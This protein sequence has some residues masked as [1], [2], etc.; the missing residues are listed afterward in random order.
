MVIITG[1]KELWEP[2]P[3][4]NFSS[5][6]AWENYT[7]FNVWSIER[8]VK[9]VGKHMKSKKIWLQMEDQNVYDVNAYYNSLE[10]ELVFPNAILQPPFVNIERDFAYNLS[11]I[12]TTIGHEMIHAFDDDGYYY[13][14]N[15]VYIKNTW[16]HENDKKEYELKQKK[17]I[18][19]YEDAAKL[20]NLKIDGSLTLSENIADIGGLMLAEDVLIEYLNEKEIYGS[21]QDKYLKEFY[22]NYATNWRSNKSIKL[23]KKSLT[24]NEH[25]YSKYRVNCV[26][27]N[28]KNFQ[29]VFNIDIG[30]EMYFEPEE[31]W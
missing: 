25:S 26:L 24:Q 19:Q 14:E 10:N 1:Y 31:I 13:D 17:I 11:S 9:L 22:V 28:S 6:D 27:S 5:T 30:D 12:G 29:R 7:L 8:D 20:D 2:D 15:G 18:K 23:F 16:W 21:A 3:D 4:I